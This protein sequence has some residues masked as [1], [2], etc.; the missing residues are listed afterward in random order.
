MRCLTAG[1][2]FSSNI[3]R[4]LPHR[5]V[6]TP[7]ITAR[8]TA[9]A[10]DTSLVS[11][12]PPS[13]ALLLRSAAFARATSFRQPAATF[14]RTTSS[15]GSLRPPSLALLLPSS[16][17]GRLRL[18][19]FFPRQPAAAFARATSSLV[20]LRP[21]SP[22]LLLPSSTYGRLRPR[23]FFP[24]QPAAASPALLLPSSACGRLRSCYFFPRQPAVAFARATSS[25]VSLRP[26]SPALLLPSSA[27][28]GMPRK[29]RRYALT[30]AHLSG[31]MISVRYAIRKSIEV[32]ITAL[33][34][35]QV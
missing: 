23:Y 17:C 16:A 3:S 19:Y 25:L 33:T 6:R 1:F 5:M 32:V 8:S 21:P 12:R 2:L 35:N 30:H 18:R 15:F 29:N 10:R 11:L 20:N 9:S 26:P 34:R 31:M 4:M 22:A 28:L 24:R 13:S 7:A 27:W 14:A